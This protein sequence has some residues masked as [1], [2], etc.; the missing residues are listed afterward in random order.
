MKPP[1]KIYSA[2]VSFFMYDTNKI[3]AKQNLH[4]NIIRSFFML[5][6]PTAV[7]L[8]FILS[9]V[10]CLYFLGFNTEWF[11]D[12][13]VLNNNYM[14]PLLCFAAI[15][16]NIALFIIFI[17]FRIICNL[18]FYLYDSDIFIPIKL[19]VKF[20]VMY[21]V[22]FV[23]KITSLLL[24]CFPFVAFSLLTLFFLH[25]GISIYSAIVFT[26]CNIILFCAGMYSFCVYIQKYQLIAVILYRHKEMSINEI[27]HMS[28]I[29]MSG[30]CKHLACLK[31]SNFFRKIPCLLVIP[32]IFILPF[33]KATEA[34]FSIEKE[35]PY[36]PKKAHTEK[37]VVFYL[38][39]VKE[40]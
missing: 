26:A 10:L 23:K 6:R 30:R 24:F 36:M 14:F 19:L 22:A 39:P 17:Y 31:L 16:E 7:F 1:S 35:K 27:F 34:D 2:V 33:T 37:S 25:Q 29:K 40:N 12:Y 3:N 20:L 38:S 9:S 28:E 11:N 4:G 8:I 13:S 21:A 5:F 15:S 32:A 18:Y